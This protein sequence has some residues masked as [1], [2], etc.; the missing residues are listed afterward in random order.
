MGK[1]RVQC[2]YTEVVF[3]CE[4]RMEEGFC[5]TM[6]THDIRGKISCLEKGRKAMVSSDYEKR[7]R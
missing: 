7:S 4:M 2:G 6:E 5:W 3:H 1:T